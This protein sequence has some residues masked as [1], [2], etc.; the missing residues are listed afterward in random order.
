MKEAMLYTKEK[1]RAVRCNLCRHGCTIKEGDYGICQVRYNE[2]G[3]LRSIFYAQPIALGVDPIEKK[4]LFHYKPGSYSMSIA[5][6]GCNF[7]CDFCQNWEISQYRASG[8][9]GKTLLDKV[10]PEAV[11]AKAKAHKCASISYT[12]TEPTIFFEYAYD[13]AALAVKEGIGNNFVTNGYMT[14]A[15]LDT[16]GPNLAA[17]NVDLKAFR[18]VTYRRVMKAQLDGVL[19]SI[20]YMKQLGIW[21]EITTLIV[22]GMNDSE[23]EIKD[24]ANFIVETGREIPWHISRFT[25]Q[26]H[27]E[28]SPPT[29]M[30]TLKKAYDIGKAAGLRYVYMGNVAGDPTENTYCYNCNEL[31]IERT[32]F[33]VRDAKITHKSTCPKCN[34]QIDGIDMGRG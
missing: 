1:D 21:V 5:T 34:S 13:T 15:A 30:A 3:T 25:P 31:L 22:P 19:D 6:P 28:D 11:V 4:P 20:R 24:I 10:P 12:Y 16:I 8:E 26:Y 32:G 2:G 14:R 27:M 23:S 9:P 7:R 29:P 33:S 17:A 18:K